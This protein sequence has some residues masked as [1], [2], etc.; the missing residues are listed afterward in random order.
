MLS[1][2]KR[3]VV[4]CILVLCIICIYCVYEIEAQRWPKWTSTTAV[5]AE[6]FFREVYGSEPNATFWEDGVYYLIGSPEQKAVRVLI[7]TKDHS[8]WKAE[9]QIVTVTKQQTTRA[10]T[11]DDHQFF[12]HFGI[13]TSRK[14]H[15]DIVF[16]IKSGFLE[17][18]E[19]LQIPPRD[20]LKSQFTVYRSVGNYTV[21][22]SYYTIHDEKGAEYKITFE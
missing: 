19:P 14:Y 13:F 4:F 20:T 9:E 22:Y 16:V 1:T 11:I 7:A 10:I 5:T 21:T 18:E 8:K 3:R 2:R 6:D 17:H 12:V 15:K